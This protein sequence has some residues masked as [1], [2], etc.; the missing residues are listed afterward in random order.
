[1]RIEGLCVRVHE[2]LLVAGQGCAK[3]CMSFAVCYFHLS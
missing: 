2:C 1:M 3:A